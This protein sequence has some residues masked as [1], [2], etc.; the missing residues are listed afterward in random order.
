MPLTFLEWFSG[1]D[2]IDLEKCKAGLEDISARLKQGKLNEAEA[3]VVRLAL[4]SRPPSSRWRKNFQSTPQMLF[5]AVAILLPVSGFGAAISYVGTAPEPARLGEAVSLSGPDGELLTQLTDYTRSIETG[6]P[7][8]SA[9]PNG[10]FLPDVNE[11]IARLAARLEATPQD[12]EGWR[13]LGWSYFQTDRYEQ[14]AAA[15][16]KALELDPSSTELKLSY[17]EAKAKAKSIGGQSVELAAAPEAASM[18]QRDTAIR[19]MV[20]RLAD[21]LETSPRDVDGWIQLMRSRVV[22]GERELAATAFR[23]AIGIFGNDA[24]ETGKIRTAATE[25]GLND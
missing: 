3:D 14:A 16:K 8:P 18:P 15:F 25:L 23:K 4:F 5:V 19:S 2:R 21:R 11:M 22:L 10:E 7:S 20:D 1:R 9:A 12:L 17:E 6:Q 24:A 13:M